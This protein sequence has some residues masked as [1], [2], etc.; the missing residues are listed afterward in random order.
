MP[1]PRSPARPEPKVAALCSC[2]HSA[3]WHSHDGKGDCEH[4]AACRCAAFDR[5]DCTNGADED[6]NW[7][8]DPQVL[9]GCREA[10]CQTCGRVAPWGAGRA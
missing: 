6:G 5:G 1:D 9:L 8:C 10:E 3:D 4:N 7:P 2:G